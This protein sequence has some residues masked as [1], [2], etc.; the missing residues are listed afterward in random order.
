MSS[1]PRR[2][3]GYVHNGCRIYP[4]V[5]LPPAPLQCLSASGVMRAVWS[6]RAWLLLA[7]S[8]SSKQAKSALLLCYFCVA[9]GLQLSGHCS[10]RGR[11]IGGI[12]GREGTL[13][14]LQ[15]L[16]TT[17]FYAGTT[18]TTKHNTNF[19]LPLWDSFSACFT[20]SKALNTW[21]REG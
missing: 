15:S 13:K 18:T 3:A 8:L 7:T 6:Q 16:I 2:G 12:H 4:A 17:I 21:V 1:A 20:D 9:K 10:P 11:F 19:H 5:L 14:Q